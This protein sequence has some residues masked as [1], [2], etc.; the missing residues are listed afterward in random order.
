MLISGEGNP[1]AFYGTLE[2]API[3]LWQHP[4][5]SQSS[6]SG[7]EKRS[8]QEEKAMVAVLEIDGWA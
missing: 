7:T 5:S 3:S 8:C 4:L 6:A 1:G 2:S